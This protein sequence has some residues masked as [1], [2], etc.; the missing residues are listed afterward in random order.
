MQS[1]QNALNLRDNQ[2]KYNHIACNS[3]DL[4]SIPG[5][6]RSPREGNGCPLQYSGLEN[7]MDREA[8]QATGHGVT[9]SWT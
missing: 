8:W 2:I 1:F 5:A 4:G 6:G 9:K 7:S 3:R